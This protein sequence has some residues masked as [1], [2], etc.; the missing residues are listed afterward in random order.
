MAP[1]IETFGATAIFN[2]DIIFSSIA[3]DIGKFWNVTKLML[4]N[5]MPSCSTAR[6]LHFPPV[7]M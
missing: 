1:S 7:Q 5:G 6:A 3:V 2:N 4:A